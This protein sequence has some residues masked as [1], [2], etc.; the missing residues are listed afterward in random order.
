MCR[1]DPKSGSTTSQHKTSKQ[2]DTH[3]LR[4]THWD[5]GC[6][7]CSLQYTHFTVKHWTGAAQRHWSCYRHSSLSS[8][9]TTFHKSKHKIS[10]I[11]QLFTGSGFHSGEMYGEV[12]DHVG[13]WSC[14][15]LLFFFDMSKP[16]HIICVCVWFTLV[17]FII[18][19]L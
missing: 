7:T 1:N 4:H 16:C 10:D 18:N 3:T 11:L 6:C 13:R 12:G 9:G 5:P 2:L 19:I 14:N 17:L 8:H 15:L